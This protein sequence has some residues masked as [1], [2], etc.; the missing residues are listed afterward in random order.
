MTPVAS[1]DGGRG[2]F[3]G[4]STTNWPSLGMEGRWEVASWAEVFLGA[5]AVEPVGVLGVDASRRASEPR[6]CL[7]VMVPRILRMASTSCTPSG[8]L[9]FFS[10]MYRSRCLP[11]EEEVKGW[12]QKGQLRSLG[13]PGF[14]A[15][16][17]LLLLLGA[18]PPASDMA[19]A[20]A[21]AA[22]GVR[23]RVVADVFYY[24][25]IV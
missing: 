2:Q 17:E 11:R 22:A 1:Q 21:A 24:A 25:V 20:A 6:G 23:V 4:W 5:V 10:F 19:A 15:A 13:A 9:G 18:L 3:G 12:A 14:A 16:G 7:L 8:G